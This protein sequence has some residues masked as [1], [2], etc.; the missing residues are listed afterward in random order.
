[1]MAH[2]NQ[3]ASFVTV[4]LPYRSAGQRDSPLAQ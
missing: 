4:G 1:L 2:T 3:H